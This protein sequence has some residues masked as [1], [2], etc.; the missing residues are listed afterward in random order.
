M[1]NEFGA[2][3]LQ[4]H[5]VYGLTVHEYFNWSTTGTHV[6]L[7]GGYHQKMR[8]REAYIMSTKAAL[9][10]T[11]P[12][13][14]LYHGGNLVVAEADMATILGATA[15]VG[16]LAELTIVDQYKDVG[17]DEAII[18]EVSGADGGSGS[19]GYLTLE[20]ELVE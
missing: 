11:E 18:V 1:G 13:I 20:Y 3:D 10:A 6:V 8:L 16:M 7:A 4:P 12:K 2:A 15:A 19:R 5:T 17:S 9:N 14:K